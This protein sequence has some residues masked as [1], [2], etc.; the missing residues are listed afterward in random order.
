MMSCTDRENV[1]FV[2]W[3]EDSHSEAPELLA[4]VMNEFLSVSSW[5]ASSA[6]ELQPHSFPSLKD[7]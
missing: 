5:A 1:R 4:E 3:G 6:Q 2:V 7:R